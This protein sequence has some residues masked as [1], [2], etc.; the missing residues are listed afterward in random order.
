M[1]KGLGMEKQDIINMLDL[2]KYNQLQY[3]QWKVGC[4]R[5]ELNMLEQ[6]KSKYRYDIFN[7]KSMINE[8]EETLAQ[9][10]AE[11]AYL[12]RECRKLRQRF[13]DYNTHNLHPIAHSEPDTDSHSNQIV[14][15]NKE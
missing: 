9:K 2:V 1:V 15:Y 12:N 13:I 10:R 8:F 6:E 4:L 5:Y 14:P 11:M 3:L 7:L